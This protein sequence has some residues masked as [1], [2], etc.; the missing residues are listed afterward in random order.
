M[1]LYTIEF[2]LHLPD[3]I[4]KTKLISLIDELSRLQMQEVQ[5]RFS[6]PG[7]SW[8]CVKTLTGVSSGKD[9]LVPQMHHE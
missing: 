8:I 5:Y 2:G 6:L 9:L 1:N 7:A 4:K 3:F